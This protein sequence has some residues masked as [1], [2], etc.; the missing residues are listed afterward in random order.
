LCK[1]DGAP[2]GGRRFSWHHLWADWALGIFRFC[3]TLPAVKEATTPLILP[4]A[5]SR[6]WWLWPNLLSLDAPAVA[7][8]WQ[9]SFARAWAVDLDWTHRALL[10]LSVWLAY[11][12]DRILDAQRLPDGPIDS[13]RHFF[14][15]KFSQTLR[16]AWGIG[17]LMATM[18]AL[19]ST[20]REMKMGSIMFGIVAVYFL[21]HHWQ[22]T[23][24]RAG[25]WKEPMAGIIFGLGI[26]FFVALNTV[27]SVAFVLMASAWLGLCV[28][29]CMMVAGW[30][31]GVDAA[32]A[33][34]SLA[35]RWVGME[36][37][38]P[39]IALGCV[40]MAL[41]SATLDAQHLPLALALAVSTLALMELARRPELFL[42][43]ARRVCADAVLLTP[44]VIFI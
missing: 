40:T 31:R 7:L 16:V 22:G 9:E 4:E 5:Q 26:L 8:I 14:A 2:F 28:M 19:Q 24:E 20:T 17:F 43:E 34:P 37:A 3:A 6:P 25:R 41:G 32:M 23:R 29:N 35:R 44:L 18:I 36:T 42:S 21:L 27:F 11:C 33:Q 13:A 30:D 15:R 1:N 39:W 38:L 12:G 10:G